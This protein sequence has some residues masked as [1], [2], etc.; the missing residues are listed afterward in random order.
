MDTDNII[1]R[2]EGRLGRL[3]LNRPAALHALN[4]SMC[5]A[6]IAALLAWR[7]DPAVTAVLVDHAGGTRGF[8]AG[9]DIRML[10]ESG[11]KDGVEARRFFHTEYRL[12]HLIHAYPKPY[13][14]LIDGV[15]MGGG[16]GISVHGDFRVATERTT[17]AMPESGIGLFPDVGGGWFLPRLPEP[18]LG[19]YLA[20]TGDRLKGDDCVTAGVAT[21]FI[22][23][24]LLGAA[25]A[26]IAGAADTHDPRAAIRS[27]LDALCEAKG[28]PV[29][30]SPGCLTPYFG[31]DSMEQIFGA[32]DGARGEGVVEWARARLETLNAKSPQT[33]KVALRQL[34]EGARCKSFAE[35]MAMEYRI[36]ARVVGRHDFLEGVRAVIV[37]KDNAPQWSPATLAGVTDAMLDEIFAPLPAGEEWTPL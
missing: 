3:T 1:A 9:G 7:E 11:A 13:V 32:L 20:L 33:L 14:A 29:V 19:V 6:M 8:C 15:T 36:G 34:R 37:D 17:F 10:A 23:S 31:F 28:K 22:P 5:E 26:Q 12:N 4:T 27:G 25:R 30:P 2:V 16:V 18:E 24:E 35:N 21:H